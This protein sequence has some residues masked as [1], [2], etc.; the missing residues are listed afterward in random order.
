[1][2]TILDAQGLK[3]LV[4]N[5]DKPLLINFWATWCG[6]CRTEFPDLV[7][8]DK[9]YRGEGL[10]FVIVSI[11]NVSLADTAVSDFLKS[12]DAEMPSY[13]LD[14]EERREITGALR[15][16]APRFTGGFPSTMLFNR[17]GRLVYLK[18]G[19]I[20]DGILR[21]QIDKVLKK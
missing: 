16:I 17:S 20:N 4:K 18:N 12:Y 15:G 11:D 9:E 8:I 13:L 5:G 14:A 21:I 1:K 3:D 19:V 10:D 2:T 6:P 7:R